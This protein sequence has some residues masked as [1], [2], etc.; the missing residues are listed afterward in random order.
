MSKH[1][2]AL[3]IERF[4]GVIVPVSL[5]TL[6]HLVFLSFASSFLNNVIK[7]KII[8]VAG[9]AKVMRSIANTSSMS[10]IRTTISGVTPGRPR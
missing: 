9:T 8:S 10:G 7:M 6:H 5:V 1:S 3:S 4:E 2:E